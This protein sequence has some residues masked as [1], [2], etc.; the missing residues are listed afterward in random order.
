LAG[1]RKHERL[2]K[3]A[4]H[5]AGHVVATHLLGKRVK[6]A[7]LKSDG[8]NAGSC[9]GGSFVS[10]IEWDS[11]AMSWRAAQ[12]IIVLFAGREAEKQFTGRRRYNNAGASDDLHKAANFIQ[13]VCGGSAEEQCA[14]SEWLLIRTRNLLASDLA[15]LLVPAVASA[16]LEK[17]TLSGKEIE[18][19]IGASVEARLRK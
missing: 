9:Q 6:I 2:R 11:E 5:E 17:T 13:R 4:F 16:L 8:D 10:A 3:T 14:Y 15:K 12:E 19:A 18:S 1:S 7:T